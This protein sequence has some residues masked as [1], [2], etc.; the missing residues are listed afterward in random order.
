M[1]Y[2]IQSFTDIVK[3]KTAITTVKSNGSTPCPQANAQ[4][5][6]KSTLQLKN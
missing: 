4:E 3:F 1:V 5:V 2:D 6:I